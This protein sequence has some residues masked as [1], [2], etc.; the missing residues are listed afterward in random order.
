MAYSKQRKIRYVIGV[1]EAG[2][3]PLAGPI[4]IGIVIAEVKKHPAL[5][6]IKDSKKLTPKKREKW[7]EIIKNNFEYKTASVGPNIIDKI[8]I[9]K[10]THLAVA[11]A[12]RKIIRHSVSNI[13]FFIMLDG[14]LKAPK[15][16][17]QE[18]IIKGDEKIPVISAASIMAKVTRDRKMA[19]LHKKYPQYSFDRHKGYGTKEHYKMLKTHGSCQIHRRSYRLE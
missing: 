6:N 18:S 13:N 19:R 15:K 8:G 7:F 17:N 14:K 16:Y 12:L 9:Q 3:G 1:D 5:K 4:T 11:R 2:R 10:A